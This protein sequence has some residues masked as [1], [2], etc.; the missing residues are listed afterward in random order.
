V[1]YN[2]SY[3]NGD[4]AL[5]STDFLDK[6]KLLSSDDWLQVL[7]DSTSSSL[8]KGVQLPSFPDLALQ[9]M[10][11]GS[12][13]H[14]ALKE[15]ANFYKAILSHLKAQGIELNSDSKA[16]NFGIVPKAHI[17]KVWGK[18]ITLVDFIDDRKYLPQA[19]VVMKKPA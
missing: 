12:S 8:W 14:Q 19:L 16:L 15:G 6:A 13:N 7:P 9:S 2:V 1:I 5:K 18:Y 11:V 10:F 3:Y 4:P 17:E